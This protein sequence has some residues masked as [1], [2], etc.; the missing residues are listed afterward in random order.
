MPL[1]P[2]RRCARLAMATLPRLPLGGL[3]PGG[4]GL[5]MDKKNQTVDSRSFK[6]R[7]GREL[8]LCYFPYFFRTN[9]RT[10]FAL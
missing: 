6:S 2:A 10:Q 7:A 5:A 9:G 4:L 8:L 3:G 1:M